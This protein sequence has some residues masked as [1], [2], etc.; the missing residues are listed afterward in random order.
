MPRS[1]ARCVPKAGLPCPRSV[2]TR[3]CWSKLTQTQVT[4]RPTDPLAL[5]LTKGTVRDASFFTDSNSKKKPVEAPIQGMIIGGKNAV[6]K[7][8]PW[9]CTNIID[10]L[11]LC[12][13][14]LITPSCVLTAAH[15]VFRWVCVAFFG[16]KFKVA[17]NSVGSNF[18]KYHQTV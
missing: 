2:I 3:A 11:M 4:R 10:D 6:Q 5:S 17:L 14:S 13:A 1:F 12:G 16:C 18:C 8:F 9:H 15:C 7:Q